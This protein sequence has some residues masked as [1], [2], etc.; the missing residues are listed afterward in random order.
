M[1]KAILTA[2]LN[3]LA[4]IVQVATYPIGLAISTAFPDI[5]Q[6]ITDTSSTIITFINGLGW[7]IDILPISFKLVLIFIIG[8]EIAK[9]TVFRSTE[10]LLRLY[11]LFQKLKFW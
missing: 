7:V 3:I 2:I 8:L 6:K 10:N 9:L 5:S 4:T 11:N 1:I